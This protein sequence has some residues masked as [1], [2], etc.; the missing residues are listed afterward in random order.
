MLDA[1]NLALID[2]LKNALAVTHPDFAN[3][4]EEIIDEH[5]RSGKP[6]IEIVENFGFLSEDET[7]ELIA[8][9]LGTEV[10]DF[11]S[12]DISK[13]VIDMVDDNTARSYNIVPVAFE[14]DVLF[15][16]LNIYII[17]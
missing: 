5:E 14:D 11:K 8:E 4:V 2:L 9:S 6:I 10:W 1:S 12:G 3:Q 7:L 13:K 17:I 15:L 16:I